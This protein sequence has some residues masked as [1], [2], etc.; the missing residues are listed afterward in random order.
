[1][2]KSG[3]R[4][5]LVLDTNVVLSALLWQGTPFRLLGAIRDADDA[6]LFSSPALLHE[7]TNVLLR[8]SMTG[9][10]AAIGA[11]AG[12]IISAYLEIVE[13]VEPTEVPAV[14]LKDPADDHVI[15]AAIAAGADLIVSGDKRHLLA[16][17]EHRGIAIVSP[18]DALAT[19]GTIGTAR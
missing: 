10:M 9:R 8:P 3:R 18:A 7:L 5:R 6:R 17:G 11:N 15:A 19:L 4:V 16:L 13:L 2:P 1:M 12:E 14:V